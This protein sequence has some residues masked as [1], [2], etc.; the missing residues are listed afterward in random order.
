M[1]SGPSKY[2][3]YAQ[4]DY[5]NASEQ[6]LADISKSYY[7]WAKPLRKGFMTDW[8]SI[9]AGGT[10]KFAD[11]MFSGLR[12]PIEDQYDIGK[13]NILAN[14]PEGGGLVEALAQLEGDR[15]TGEANILNQIW[16]DSMNKMYGTMSGAPQIAI[17]GLGQA[18]GVAGQ[19]QSAALGA[20]AQAAQAEASAMQLCCFNFLEAEGEI[21]SSV[22]RY[23]DQHFSEDGAVSKGYRLSAKYLVPFM[24]KYRKGKLLVRLSMTK[25]LRAYAQWFY[26]ENKYG[27]IFMPI[28]HGWLTFWKIAGRY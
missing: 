4:G 26:G 3:P 15:S 23:R 6:A 22:R 20:S 13:K 17:S 24:R 12:R 25:P 9:M 19:R 10:P 1:G 27:W 21:H 18:A 7:N 8:K 28:V 14:T 16:M 11:T 5:P 2:K